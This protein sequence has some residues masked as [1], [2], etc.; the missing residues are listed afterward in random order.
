MPAS[1]TAII[2]A[3]V[4]LLSLAA[5]PAWAY[6]A[7]VGN[8]A[9]N[10]KGYDIVNHEAIEL[11][12]YLGQWVLVEHW[13]TWCGSCMAELPNLITK[14]RPYVRDGRLSVITVSSDTAEDL[15]RL[16]QAI[17][18]QRLP[19]PVIYDGGIYDP[20]EIGRALP[21]VEWN[22]RGWPA[23]FLIDP[24]GVIVANEVRGEDL[25]EIL[26]FYLSGNA[27]VVSL[28]GYA[29]ENADRSISIFAEVGNTS[30]EPVR[31]TAWVYTADWTW[32]EDCIV[33][34]EESGMAENPET[35]LVSF[36]DFCES[37]AE[38]V[39]PADEAIDYYSCW[40]EATVPGTEHIGPADYPG[41][42]FEVRTND[43]LLVED[44]YYDEE[45]ADC[46]VIP[47][48]E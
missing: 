43:I 38:I 11:D 40:L 20:D 17:R 5:L 14:T 48:A 37:V 29:R 35:V 47:R 15:P 6:D 3:I 1:R 13:A 32:D 46:R 33:I 26:D 45:I 27:P 7:N 4:I 23:T 28:C 16:K 39:L 10:F 12:D 44:F 18:Q 21:A 36:D 31:V 42:R 30:R 9:A 25:A 19:Y 8:R 41:I 2:C 22:V 24:Q 34:N